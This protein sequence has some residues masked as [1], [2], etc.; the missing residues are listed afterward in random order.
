MLLAECVARE[1]PQQA[2]TWLDDA[3]PQ[4]DGEWRARAERLRATLAE[5]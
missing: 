5:R 3:L 1:Q 4:L 2:R